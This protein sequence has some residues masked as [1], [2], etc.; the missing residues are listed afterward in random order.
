MMDKKEQAVYYK[1]N[2]Y[3]CCQ[4]VIAVYADELGI[5]LEEAKR[6]GVAFGSGMGCMQ[7]TCGA[8]VG[9][10]IVLGKKT[11]TGAKMHATARRLMMDFTDKCGASV[12][13]DLKG[14]LTGRM[15]CSCDDCIRNA[16]DS[17]DNI[18][19]EK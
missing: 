19:L 15:L 10:G 1:H 7:A 4:A 13:I 18:L 11:Y 12:C 9:A 16:I 2:G 5:D 3:N 14:V 8:L 6:L 17:L